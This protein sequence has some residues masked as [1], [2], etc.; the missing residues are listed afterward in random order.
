MGGMGDREWKGVAVKGQHEGSL[1]QNRCVLTGVVTSIQC[2]RSAQ[3][4][5]HMHTRVP[6]CCVS[7]SVLAVTLC[8]IM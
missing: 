7:V 1:G 5:R 2:D 3:N 6:K 4:E 8:S